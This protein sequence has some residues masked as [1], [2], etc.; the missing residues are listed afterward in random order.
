MHPKTSSKPPTIQEIFVRTRNALVASGI[1]DS[2]IEAEVL[3][4]HLLSMDRSEYFASLTDSINSANS[5]KLNT[6]VNLRLAGEPLAYITGIRE[7]YGLEFAVN[8]DV[9]IPRQ[10]TELL[11]DLALEYISNRQKNGRSL[12]S[13]VADVCTGSGAVGVALAVNCPS[14][15]I[16]ATDISQAAIEV[17]KQNAL[18]HKVADRVRFVRNDLIDGVQDPFDLILSNPPYIPHGMLDTLDIEVRNEP[19]I[20]LD[21]GSDG[22][23]IFRRLIQQSEAMLHEF[24]ALIVELMPEQMDAALELAGETFPNAEVGYTE[25]LAGNARALTVYSGG[26]N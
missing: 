15:R 13:T 1:N 9:L 4:R 3:I 26:Q 19:S 18:T 14:A 11:V 20:A 2:D 16:Y 7:F 6:L 10:E 12:V 8:R 23:E 5:D 21:G 17:A 25:D 22:L 24:G